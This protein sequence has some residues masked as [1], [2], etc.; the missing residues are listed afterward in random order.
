MTPL[1]SDTLPPG[2]A[3]AGLEPLR[4]VRSRW[5]TLIAAVLTV[6]MAAG[7]ARQL[8]QHGWQGLARSAPHSPWF[9]LCFAA[10]YMTLPMGDWLIFRRL[11]NIPASGLAALIKK[12][13]A[14]D[15][16]INYTGE[17]F[18]YAWARARSAIVAAPFGAIKDV[19]IL[20]AIAGNAVTLL[21]VV[22][23]LPVVH[24]WLSPGDFRKGL[25]S[26]VALVA[27]SL[28]FLLFSRRVFSLPRRD[29]WVVFAIQGARVILSSSLTA[30]AWHFALPD[31]SVAMWLFLAA[32]RLLVSR[33]PFL[34]N[35]EL[36]FFTF[37]SW[38][39]GQ[40]EALVQ[41]LAFFAG[42]TL[43]TNALGLLLFGG[44]GLVTRGKP[45]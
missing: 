31:V 41:L 37:A 3:L 35:K 38:L 29:L 28:P 10:F 19:S 23:A 15:V 6:A 1:A 16:L 20:S 24:D 7:L 4:S 34:P 8:L 5:P 44:W 26:T 14:N 18:F 27:I 11:W 40:H 32:G 22:V 25:W 39:I 42:L 2:A 30:L 45:W 12:R 13:I 33:L 17:A 43:A 21:L 36:A 9:Y